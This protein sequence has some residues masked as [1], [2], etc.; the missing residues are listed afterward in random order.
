MPLKSENITILTTKVSVPLEYSGTFTDWQ[1]KLNAAIAAFPGFVSLEILSV[2]EGNQKVW[3]IVQRFSD[4]EKFSD[5]RQS[6]EYKTLIEELKSSLGK[7][8]NTIQEIQANASD[9]QGGVTEVFVTE[10]SP[11]KEDV[12]REWL[13]KIHQVEAKFPGFKGMYVQSPRTNQG[14]NWISLLRFD[15][16]E[17]LDKWLSSPEREQ[18]L[19]ESKPLITSLESHRV[20]SPYEGWFAS[21]AKTGDIPPVWKQTMLVLLVLFPIIMLELRF[22]NPLTASLN[23]AAAT[24][25]GNA[26]SVALIAW[27]MMPIAIALLSW[28]LSPKG[29][30]TQKTTIIGTLLVIGLYLLEIAIFWRIL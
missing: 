2:Q 19:I 1:A 25:I 9:L 30:Q 29:P 14:R 18:I 15:T 6:N 5:W 21:L 20:I 10:V 11:D 8:F 24:F 7:S 23:P 3:T 28:W 16:L 17:N 12:Y 4:A 26:L 22:L 27:P 13:A